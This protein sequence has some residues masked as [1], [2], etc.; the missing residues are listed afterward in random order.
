MLVVSKLPCKL[1]RLVLAHLMNAS[2]VPVRFRKSL[3]PT[4]HVVPCTMSSVVASSGVPMKFSTP[5][6]PTQE[7]LASWALRVALLI[8]RVDFSMTSPDPLTEAVRWMLRVDVLCKVCEGSLLDSQ[9]N[10]GS[11]IPNPSQYHVTESV[12][13]IVMLLVFTVTN[14]GSKKGRTTGAFS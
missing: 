1:T 2:W 12:W 4:I 14:G 9:V 6:S 13:L 10:T 3:H 8:C 7:K 11:G 5:F